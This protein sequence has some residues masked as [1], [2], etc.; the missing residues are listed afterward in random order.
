MG[1]SYKN[2]KDESSI[3]A[4]KNEEKKENINLIF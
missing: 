2:N 1:P 3:G 4:V